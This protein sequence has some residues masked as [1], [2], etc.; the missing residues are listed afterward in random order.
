MEKCKVITVTGTKGK[1]TVVTVLSQ[2]MRKL[3]GA[4]V[5]HVTTTG[6][7]VNGER[8]SEQDESKNVW[9][10]VPS[11]CPGRFMY[12][13]LNFENEGIA[14]LEASLGSSSING[15]GYSWHDIGIFLDVFEDH[16]GSSN[17]IQ[18]Q[19]DIVN[20]K[21]FIFSRIRRRTGWAIYNSDDSQVCSAVDSIDESVKHLTFGLKDNLDSEYH[22]YIDNNH[23]VYKSSEERITVIELS[24]VVWTFNGFFTPSVYNLMAVIAGAI[25]FYKGELPENLAEVLKETRLSHYGG[26]LTLMRSDKGTTILADYAHEKESLR[27]I[28]TLARNLIKDD[29]KVIGIVRLAYD[30]TD[31]HIKKTAEAISNSFD[32]FIVYDKIDG[33][34]KY[35]KEDL[36]SKLFVQETGKTSQT[37]Y[38]ALI[39]CGA[40]A[41]RIIREDEAILRANEIAGPKDIVVHIVN[42]NIKRSVDWLLEYFKADF[43]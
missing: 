17:R 38:D 27:S 20:A 26:R 18:S 23:V 39:D 15:L 28:A 32:E 10:L 29:G 24:D 33:H 37:F 2:V 14:V 3:S 34:Y 42:D 25:A 30:R 16:I 41:E 4:D 35:P 21:R 22:I 31:E 19:T 7:F 8:K 5:L 36:Q 40:K 11:V 12:E 9:G 13:C 1:T 43:I 6:H